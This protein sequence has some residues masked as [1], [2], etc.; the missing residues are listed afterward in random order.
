MRASCCESER[1]GPLGLE[2]P[3]ALE[4]AARSRGDLLGELEILGRE[5]PLR[6]EADEDERGRLAAHRDREERRKRRRRPVR[7]EARVG[8]EVGCGEHVA[9]GRRLG[10]RAR[11]RQR[12][13]LVRDVVAAGNREAARLADEHRREVAAERLGCGERGRVVGIRKRERLTEERGDAIEAA[14]HARLMRPLGEGLGVPQRERGERREGAEQLLVVPVEL[15]RRV[16]DA[17]A[18]HAERLAAR[19]PSARRA[20]ARTRRRRVRDRRGDRLVV[21]DRDR[22]AGD[23]RRGR[24]ALLGRELEADER[25]VEAV[26]RGAAKD[27]ALAVEE[28][29]VG[30]VGL[31]QLRHLLDE[32]A[33]HRLELE[34]AGDDLRR[35]EQR[36][37]LLEAAAVLGQRVAERDRGAKPLERE[38]R[39]GRERLQERRAPRP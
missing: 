25:R 9:V 20:P 18:D 5:P 35:E 15:A 16:L 8:R 33:Q 23:D 32:Q 37:L 19:T 13:Q 7:V 36:G 27:V 6:P 39:L 11:D 28:V 2:Q 24:Y 38:R 1:A 29:A 22:A 10:E 21:V 26:H 31:E 30:G 17:D 4:R 12:P 14:L 3:A 34:L